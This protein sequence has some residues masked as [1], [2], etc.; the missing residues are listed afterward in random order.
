MYR[1]LAPL[2]KPRAAETQRLIDE[3][4]AAQSR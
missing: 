3:L 1:I 2:S 4:N